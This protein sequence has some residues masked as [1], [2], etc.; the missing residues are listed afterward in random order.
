MINERPDSMNLAT[1]SDLWRE[2]RGDGYDGS[3]RGDDGVS[4]RPLHP[5]AS[6]AVVG[7]RPSMK[8]T[9]ADHRPDRSTLRHLRDID[10]QS[11]ERQRKLVFAATLTLARLVT[12]EHIEPHAAD[13]LR[14]VIEELDAA[15]RRAPGDVR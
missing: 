2:H 9:R 8:A 3:S 10:G 12:D 4:P 11:A 13:R 15:I 6:I 7:A 14:A 5:T 1:P